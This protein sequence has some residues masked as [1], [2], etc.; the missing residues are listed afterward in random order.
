MFVYPYHRLNRQR[1]LI[2]LEQLRVRQAL[3]TTGYKA[4]SFRTDGCG[5]L[6]IMI[7]LLLLLLLILLLLIIII[8][9]ITIIIMDIYGALSRAPT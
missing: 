4:Y 3:N 6:M 1:E 5:V 7:L 8:I 2:A 9:I